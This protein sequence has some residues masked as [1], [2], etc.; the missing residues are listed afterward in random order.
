MKLRSMPDRS[1]CRPSSSVRAHGPRRHRAPRW[2]AAAAA[3][4][5][6]AGTGGAGGT[7]RRRGQR[8]HDGR[9]R[10][11]GTGRRGRHRGGRRWRR[12][13]RRGHGRRR[14]C[15]GRWRRV[16]NSR[17]RGQRRGHRGNGGGGAAGTAAAAAPR[18]PAAVARAAA[19]AAPPAGGTGG[20][21]GAGGR[22]GRGGTGG[23][24]GSAGT[25][26]A[27]RPLWDWVGVIGTGQSLAVGGH[28]N[29]PAMPIGATTQRFHNLKLSLG[30]ATVPPFDPT[31]T[32]LSLVPLVE[33]IRAIATGYPSPYPR[34]I[35][36]ESFHT[37]MADELSTLVMASQ[38][39]DYVT[40]HTVVGE[41]GQAISRPAEGRARHRL[42]GPRLRGVA[43]RGRRDRAPR[44]GAGQE[45]RRRRDRADARRIRRRQRD[46]RGRHGEAVADYNQ[47][48]P[49]ADRPDRGHADP[50][51]AVAAA[52]GADRR[53][54]QLDGDAGAVAHR[55]GPSRRHHLHGAEVPVRLRQRQ[56]PPHQPGLR[57]AG[58]EIRGGVVPA[59]GARRTPGS[60]CSRPASSAAPP[61]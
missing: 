49:G 39:R 17:C 15:R 26:G 27:P 55:P 58:R 18:E 20:A 28:G 6:A 56:H 48:L 22:G 5:D 60:R 12:Q 13:R 10:R 54:G 34:N 24:G 51:A 2:A 50:D 43:V 36:G 19:A 42:D 32:M 4:L 7:R 31:N 23:G 21:Q 8:R 9:R 37:A 35:Y 61:A 53:G 29:A 40:V 59:R 46:V 41:A 45:L 3:M 25:G 38:S 44:Q 14:R 16:R 33:T 57:T 52:L 47:D 1:R 30:N 11:R